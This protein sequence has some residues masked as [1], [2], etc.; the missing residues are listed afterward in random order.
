MIQSICKY[1]IK[2]C[3]LLI[4]Y[5]CQ[6]QNCYVVCN[7]ITIT[8]NVANFAITVDTKNYY[9]IIIYDFGEF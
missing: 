4:A 7:L 2:F 1:K 5:P 8:K 9:K 6:W 3:T